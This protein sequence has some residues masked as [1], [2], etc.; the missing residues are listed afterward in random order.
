MKTYYVEYEIFGRYIPG[1]RGSQ[2][3]PPEPPTVEVTR[4]IR[5]YPATEGR[6]YREDVDYEDTFDEVERILILDRLHE[7]GAESD[8]PYDPE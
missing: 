2:Q 8:E 3:D 5:V 7:C 6:Y 4:V 1:Y